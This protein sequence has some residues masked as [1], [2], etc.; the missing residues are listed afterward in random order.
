MTHPV[1]KSLWR[2]VRVGLSFPN[3]AAV[4]GPDV[5]KKIIIQMLLFSVF[6]HIFVVHLKHCDFNCFWL[7][8]GSVQVKNIKVLLFNIC[9]QSLNNKWWSSSVLSLPAGFF[10]RWT[11]QWCACSSS[12]RLN[13]TCSLDPGS[14][15][16]A[17]VSVT[18]VCSVQMCQHVTV[19]FP[20][21]FST[22]AFQRRVGL[23]ESCPS[24][25]KHMFC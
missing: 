7:S 12:R 17:A 23:W 13:R 2:D 18:S 16:L 20:R 10:S 24:S 8:P 21:S 22:Q 25:T 6:S 14:L 19:H 3:A 11:Q 9:W 4:L 1:Y 5:H 15:S